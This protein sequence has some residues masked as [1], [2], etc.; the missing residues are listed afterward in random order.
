MDLKV[1]AEQGLISVTYLPRD[2]KTAE[3]I[4]DILREIEGVQEILCTMA[5]ANLLWIQERFDPASAAVGQLLDIAGKWNAAVEL[6]RLVEPGGEAI[7]EEESEERAESAA[8]PVP[9]VEDPARYGGILDDAEVEA[10]SAEDAGFRA[11]RSQLIDAGRAGGH[12]V[13]RGGAKEILRRLD[14][15]AP[16]S[17]VVVGDVYADKSASVRKRLRR[18]MVGHLADNLR[19]PVI[20]SEEMQSQYLFGSR[21]WLALIR[22]AALAALLFGLV[23]ANQIEVLSFT[24]AEGVRH[25]IISTLCLFVFVP[26]FA[27]SYGNFARYLLRLLKFE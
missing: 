24:S 8:A 25:R 1:R 21:Q 17:L 14:R 2:Q 20:E 5:S 12:R 3:L 15:T 11:T 4:P 9:E 27:H 6:I 19:V 10:E 16:Y 22:Y 23:F 13:I 18:E 26:I 7:V